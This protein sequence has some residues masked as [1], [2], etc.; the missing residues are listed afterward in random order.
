MPDRLISPDGAPCGQFANYVKC[1][2]DSNDS[3]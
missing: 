3:A 1:F 2:T